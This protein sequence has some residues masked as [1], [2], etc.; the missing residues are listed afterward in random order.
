M[1]PVSL[2]SDS[3]I[4]SSSQEAQV[5]EPAKKKRDTKKTAPS[6]RAST[7]QRTGTL[8]VKL[9]NPNS[10]LKVGHS[11]LKT[12]PHPK[13]SQEERSSKDLVGDGAI[14]GD[15]EFKKQN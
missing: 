12:T 6:T 8:S 11:K 14:V 10:I 5:L 4:S 1:I 13:A 3:E 15:G 7:G 2:A 9:E